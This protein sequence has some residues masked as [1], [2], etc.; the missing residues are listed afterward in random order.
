MKTEFKLYEKNDY[1]DLLKM[2]ISLYR[3]D[4]A[5]EPIDEEKINRTIAEYRQN[6]E[7]VSI[8]MLQRKKENIG[9]AILVY[10]WSNEYGGNIITIDEL[11]VRAAYRSQGIA[12][13]FFSFLEQMENK[14]AF[15]LET[16]PANQRALE[17]YRRLGFVPSE[18]T[19]MIKKA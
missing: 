12:T 13:E 3:E 2:I 9:Y 10:F 19:H 5:G 16:T 14:A 4:P 17:Y 11:Y 6:P 8:Y 1:Q 7:K 15:Q 18:N